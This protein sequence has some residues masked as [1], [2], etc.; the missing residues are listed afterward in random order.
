MEKEVTDAEVEDLKRQLEDMKTEREKVSNN[1]YDNMLAETNL[2]HHCTLH[3][4][5]L[6]KITVLC[7][8]SAFSALRRM[9]RIRNR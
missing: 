3:F 7:A 8:E 4:G 6:S 5:A 1:L 9:I 2:L